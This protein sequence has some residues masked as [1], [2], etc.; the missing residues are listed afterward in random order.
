MLIKKYFTIVNI[1]T[2]PYNE[3]TQY[4]SMTTVEH[5][6][7]SR[8]TLHI[9]EKVTKCYKFNYYKKYSSRFTKPN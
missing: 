2:I 4:T 3:I 9:N 7:H 8:T 6:L 5:L 1:Q